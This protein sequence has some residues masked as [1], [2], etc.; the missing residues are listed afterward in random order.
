[1]VDAV[2]GGGAKQQRIAVRFGLGDQRGTDVAAGTGLVVNDNRLAQLP[3][4]RRAHGTRHLVD[5]AAGG[6]RHDQGDGPRWIVI[7][8]CGQGGKG[9]GGRQ[10]SGQ[11]V[12]GSQA[13]WS[14]PSIRK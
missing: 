13:H 2:G 1:R 12:F 3:A 7:G 5:G 4:Q 8:R 11:P 6:E 9:Q 14:P 10:G